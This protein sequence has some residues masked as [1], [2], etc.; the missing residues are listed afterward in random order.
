MWEFMRQ[1]GLSGPKVILLDFG[2]A[3][4]KAAFVQIDLEKKMGY[5]TAFSKRDYVDVLKETPSGTNQDVWHIGLPPFEELV[6]L[7]NEV[8]VEVSEAAKS[9]TKEALIVLGGTFLRGEFFQWRGTRDHSSSRITESEFQD[10]LV[11]VLKEYKE[12]LHKKQALEAIV[13]GML[14]QVKI[15]GYRISNPIGFK[16][17]D[18]EISV[19][20]FLFSEQQKKFWQE[21]S[22]AAKIDFHSIIPS[23]WSTMR[24]QMRHALTDYGA[25]FVD[26]GDVNTDVVV[27]RDSIVESMRT[28]PEGAKLLRDGIMEILDAD[29]EEINEILLKYEQGL[30]DEVIVKKIEA[31]LKDAVGAFREKIVALL[32]EL[33]GNVALPSLL[34]F[35]GGGM[36]FGLLNRMMTQFSWSDVLPF[37][38]RPRSEV[39]LASEI[40]DIVDLTKKLSGPEFV[41]L[42]A[43]ARWISRHYQ[44]LSKAESF[45]KGAVKLM[46]D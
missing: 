43:S 18:V 17:R 36:R 12:N 14:Q 39:L 25:V 33:A 2:S 5:I 7:T 9:K 8:V 19:F 38:Q 23:V 20:L 41:P 34:V 15:D 35:V 27:V 26:I 30:L 42:L 45:F 40:K 22:K 28:I 29:E 6:E 1:P 21:F 13:N 24:S 4:L 46:E 16:G 37:V 31:G 44:I 3:S 10:I 32:K 11:S